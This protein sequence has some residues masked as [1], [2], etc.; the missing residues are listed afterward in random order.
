VATA[1]DAFIRLVHK[2]Q[3]FNIRKGVD[4]FASHQLLKGIPTRPR[5]AVLQYYAHLGMIFSTFFDPVQGTANTSVTYPTY[6]AI[7]NRR[8][9]YAKTTMD[10]LRIRLAI[11]YYYI[12]LAWDI[13]AEK[14]T[15]GSVLKKKKKR[16]KEKKKKKGEKYNHTKW[17]YAAKANFIRS[18]WVVY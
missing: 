1:G 14:T 3:Y 2:V 12:L 8:G 16:E 6:L 15:L 7:G 17:K 4:R 13:S 10:S 5:S 11:R 18:D 9:N